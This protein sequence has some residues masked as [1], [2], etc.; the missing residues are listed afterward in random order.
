MGIGAFFAL[1][2]VGSFAYAFL[3]LSSEQ[4]RLGG[5]KP[6]EAAQAAGL[7]AGQRILLTSVISE[8]NPP[9]IHDLVVA[10][11][12]TQGDDNSWNPRKRYHRPLVV[13]RDGVEL[14]VTLR[15]P[16]PR[17]R[18]AVIPNPESNLWRWVGLRRGDTLTVVGTVTAT[19]PLTLWGED[20]FA[21]GVDE[22]RRYLTRAR[23]YVVPFSVVCLLLGVALIVGGIR[24]PG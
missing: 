18:H 8:K 4:R 3:A 2:A 20:A 10:C 9:L 24:R 23:W 13:A 15:Q 22:Y 17:G 12:E 19:S 7:R 21:G 5:L 6:F 1:L 16:C 14:T 11:E